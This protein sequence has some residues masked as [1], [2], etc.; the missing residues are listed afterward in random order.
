MPSRKQD[1]LSLGQLY[2]A[3]PDGR[4]TDALQVTVLNLTKGSTAKS[5][6]PGVKAETQSSGPRYKTQVAGTEASVPVYKQKRVRVSCSCP[7]YMF[8]WEYANNYH[9]AGPLV[10]GNG[11]PPLQTNPSL[12]P[13]LCI[14]KGEMITTRDNGKIPIQLVKRGMRVLTHFGFFEV[15]DTLRTGINQP[16]LKITFE[17]GRSIRLTSNHSLLAGK[18]LEKTLPDIPVTDSVDS[19]LKDISEIPKTDFIWTP[20]SVLNTDWFVLCSV[21]NESAP[22]DYKEDIYDIVLSVDR[23][24]KVESTYDSDVYNLT[25]KTAGCFTVN[26][27][28][29]KN[30][31]HLAALALEISRQKI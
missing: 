28:V 27:L 17:S 29:V 15:I 8:N 1:G 11:D 16:C 18:K 25:V 10:Y 20:A 26:D 14:A 7:D 23:V 24:L 2:K 12:N 9:N 21:L 3:T 5:G 6:F 19:S 22:I 30:C 31:K 4:K 13:G